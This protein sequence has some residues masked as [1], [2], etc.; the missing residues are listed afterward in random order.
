MYQQRISTAHRGAIVIM[1]DQSAS[2]GNEV[3]YKYLRTT[4]ADVAVVAAGRLIQELALRCRSGYEWRNY[5][6]ICVVGYSGHGIVPLLSD[7]LEFCTLDQQ[8]AMRKK[9][10]HRID[11]NLPRS[12]SDPHIRDDRYLLLPCH[13]GRT[14]MYSAFRAV[15][16]MVRGWC[17]RQACVDN[18]PP[19]VFNI[20]DGMFNDAN[21]EQMMRAAESLRS[22]G[23]TDGNT[24]LINITYNSGGVNSGSY[25]T[26][27]QEPLPFAAGVKRL[28]EMSSV[29]PDELYPR[30]RGA[31]D[32]PYFPPYRFFCY[33]SSPEEIISLLSIGTTS[34]LF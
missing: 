8:L 15:T 32:T 10:P 11:I 9:L 13:E 12:T 27:E 14:P 2:M 17:R 31:L 22:T 4:K 24:L 7:K 30:L 19:I 16:N 6:D 1:I 21:P 28:F 33:N 34:I 20:T 29:V 3:P 18:F 26:S 5:F 25:L 23:T